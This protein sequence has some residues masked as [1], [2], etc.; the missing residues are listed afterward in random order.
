MLDLEST[1]TPGSCIIYLLRLKIRIF[2]VSRMLRFRAINQRV[3]LK[4][5]KMVTVAITMEI[6]LSMK[7]IS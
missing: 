7:N 1:C 3:R 4:K 2:S 5:G 6:G